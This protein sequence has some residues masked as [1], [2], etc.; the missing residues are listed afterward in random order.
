MLFNSG[1]TSNDGVQWWKDL[2]R[3]RSKVDRP[4]TMPFKGGTMSFKVGTMPFKVGTMPFK[5]G[6]MPFKGGTML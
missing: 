4:G 6:T 5:G 1:T 2:E 3:Y